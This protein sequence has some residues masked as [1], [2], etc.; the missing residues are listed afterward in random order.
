MRPIKTRLSAGSVFVMQSGL[1]AAQ[2]WPALQRFVAVSFPVRKIESNPKERVKVKS[3]IGSVLEKNPDCDVML[4]S[5]DF[6]S[7]NDLAS[8]HSERVAFASLGGL[9]LGQPISPPVR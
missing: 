2:R 1:F 3:E 7:F 6:D 8:D 9:P 5:R 4:Q